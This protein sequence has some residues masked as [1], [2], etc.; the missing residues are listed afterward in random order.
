MFAFILRRIIQAVFVMLVVGF[1]AFSLFRYVGDP[2]SIMLGQEATAADRVRL[3]RDL[4]LDRS[5][6]V[7]FGHFVVNAAQGQ[8]GIAYHM[9]RPSQ[10]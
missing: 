7:Q 2:V 10:P 4:G 8:F 6:V 1:V 3:T 5:F 9:G